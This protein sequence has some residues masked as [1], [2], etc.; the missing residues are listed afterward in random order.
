MAAGDFEK[1]HVFKAFSLFLNKN[2]LSFAPMNKLNMHAV[3]N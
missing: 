3:R 2:Y 1:R